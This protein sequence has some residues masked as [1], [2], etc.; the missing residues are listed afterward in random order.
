MISMFKG[1]PIYSK[2]SFI[3]GGVS[4]WGCWILAFVYE[5]ISFFC[6]GLISMVFFA[7]ITLFSGLLP[8]MYIKKNW[9]AEVSV[10]IST[11]KG[12]VISFVTD[13]GRSGISADC[14]IGDRVR[15]YVNPKNNKEYM[16]DVEYEQ[17][18]I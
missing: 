8:D 18:K 9:T 13:T 5:N 10:I 6:L 3:L 4:L 17:D 16:F 12:D 11:E 1:L 14:K 2:I 15:F 7:L